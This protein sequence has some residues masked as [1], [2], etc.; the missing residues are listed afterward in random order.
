M[1]CDPL[2]MSLYVSKCGVYIYIYIYIMN[3]W[4]NCVSDV[5]LDIICFGC[6]CFLYRAQVNITIVSC[7]LKLLSLVYASIVTATNCATIHVYQAYILHTLTN[8]TWPVLGS[9]FSNCHPPNK[10]RISFLGGWT[11]NKK[12]QWYVCVRIPSIYGGEFE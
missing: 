12:Y 9:G 11:K 1:D 4:I 10:Q 3:I 7:W 2:M 5:I 8:K 6:P